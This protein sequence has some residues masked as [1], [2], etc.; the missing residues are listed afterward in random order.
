MDRKERRQALQAALQE[1]ILVLDGAMGTMLHEVRLRPEDGP[2]LDGCVEYLVKSRPDAVLQV[3][4]AYLEAGADI[5]ETDTFGGTRI[6]LAEFHQQDAAYELN[7][8]AA[9]L[10]RL[11]ADEH[12]RPG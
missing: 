11:A 6:V 5:V 2:A 10:A 4:R 7:F 9:Q 3:H 8:Q 1:R 12:S